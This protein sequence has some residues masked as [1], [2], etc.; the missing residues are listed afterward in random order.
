MLRRQNAREQTELRRKRREYERLKQELEDGVSD[1]ELSTQDDAHV[2]PPPPVSTETCKLAGE[3]TSVGW[4]PEPDKVAA[5]LRK[6]PGARA[7][8]GSRADERRGRRRRGGGRGG[9]RESESRG[10]ARARRCSV[11]AGRLR[12]D[13]RRQEGEEGQEG[14]GEEEARA[15]GA[16]SEA[17]GRRFVWKAR[18]GPL[19]LVLGLSPEEEE[20]GPEASV[21]MVLR[22]QEGRRSAK[23]KPRKSKDKDSW[24]EFR[25]RRQRSEV[26]RTFTGRAG[27]LMRS[28]S[29]WGASRTPSVMLF[30][31]KKRA[32]KAEADHL[33]AVRALPTPKELKAMEKKKAEDEW[34]VLAPRAVYAIVATSHAIDVDA[35]HA[36]CATRSSAGHGPRRHGR[37]PRA[38]CII[39][40]IRLEP[41]HAAAVGRGLRPIGRR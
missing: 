4:L 36:G 24:K 22:P 6:E 15:G 33:A 16:R 25:K 28:A 39:D 37:R 29:A 8:Q 10:H 19:S 20:G 12:R 41:L 17:R 1:E 26:E 13:G 32:E 31:R 34:C 30:E 7:R 40:K 3:W 27:R 38:H 23:V 14:R 18:V 9:R 35:P 5:R 11:S 2:L 21:E